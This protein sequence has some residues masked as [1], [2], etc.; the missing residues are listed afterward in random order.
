[1][2]KF[3]TDLGLTVV[4]NNR[5][6]ISPY[7]I[8]LFIPELNLAIEYNGLPWHSE[9]FGNKGPKYHLNKTTMCANVG[10][11]LI[12]IFS[13]DFYNSKNIVESILRNAVG[14]NAN[15]ISTPSRYN[16]QYFPLS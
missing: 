13:N 5:S 11:K 14:K 2:A 1:M 6:I 7:E 4:I 16:T 15:R 8:D 12:H 10:I 9:L 3:L